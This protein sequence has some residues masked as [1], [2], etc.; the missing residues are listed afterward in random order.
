MSTQGHR[1]R[2]GQLEI[3]AEEE[4]EGNSEFVLIQY[5]GGSH[6]TWSE[7]IARLCNRFWCIAVDLLGWGNSDR[8]A[9]DYGPYAQVDDVEGVVDRLNVKDFVLIGHS[10]GGTIR[11]WRHRTSWFSTFPIS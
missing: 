11:H 5:S 3:Y 4:G 7:V 8:R 2:I 9:K 10:M 6:R 1:I